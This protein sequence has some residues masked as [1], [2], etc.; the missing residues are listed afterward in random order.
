MSISES[1]KRDKLVE[2]I[3]TKIIAQTVM[4]RMS[5]K[6]IGAEE[7]KILPDLLIQVKL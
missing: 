4:G 3:V 7:L 1:K 6:Q 5:S 2:C